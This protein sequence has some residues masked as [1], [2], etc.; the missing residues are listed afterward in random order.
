MLGK[1]GVIDYSEKWIIYPQYDPI[2][3]I[4]DSLYF[5]RSKKITFL[6]GLPANLIYFTS[7]KIKV[8]TG[9][10]EETLAETCG[11]NHK[12]KSELFL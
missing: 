2:E 7:N 5:Q 11:F 12:R 10:L 3:L 9:N 6:R 8:G 1:Y 4:N